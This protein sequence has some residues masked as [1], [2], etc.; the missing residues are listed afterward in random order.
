MSRLVKAICPACQAKLV[1]TPPQ[2][3]R[4]ERPN[5]YRLASPSQRSRIQLSSTSAMCHSNQ[6]IELQLFD[7]TQCICSA[8]R[9]P[10]EHFSRNSPRAHRSPL[11][12]RFPHPIPRAVR[13]LCPMRRPPSWQVLCRPF[14]R[15]QQQAWAPVLAALAER[16]P[17]SAVAV[18][19][20]LA[21]ELGP[22]LGRALP[23]G[24]RRRR[25]PR[26]DEQPLPAPWRRL[27]RAWSAGPHA[28]R[29]LVAPV[30][31]GGRAIP[32]PAAIGAPLRALDHAA[33]RLCARG[34]RRTSGWRH[35]QAVA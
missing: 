28:L 29:L 33:V 2:T 7:G 15:S 19:G 23:R 21:G 17:A 24:Y 9:L 34:F 31:V 32:V 10:A 14:R 22:P 20:H 25:Q 18:A 16:A 5:G 8:A 3:S 12:G 11:L 35:S 4:T 26:L 1:M 6:A 27:A 30:V 13:P